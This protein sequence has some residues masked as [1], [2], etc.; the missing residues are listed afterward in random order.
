MSK[1]WHVK[2]CLETCKDYKKTKTFNELPSD[3]ILRNRE[4]ESL[5][6]CPDKDFK[7][8]LISNR[9]AYIIHSFLFLRRGGSSTFF[10]L[11]FRGTVKIT[12]SKLFEL[13]VSNLTLLLSIK[14]N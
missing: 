7:N 9:L 12:Q 13:P 8:I 11:W 14:V 10:N 1:R 6:I 5:N 2:C 3:N 4:L